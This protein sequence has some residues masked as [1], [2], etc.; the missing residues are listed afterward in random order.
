MV[1]ERPPPVEEALRKVKLVVDARFEYR[2]VAVTPDDE[3]RVRTD[4]EA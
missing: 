3:A 2:L 1:V 4:D